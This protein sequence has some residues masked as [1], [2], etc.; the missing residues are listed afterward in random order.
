M[1]GKAL[2]KI[3][4]GQC[5]DLANVYWA[6]LFG[7]GLK[8]AG[9][10][11]IPNVNNF[12][13]EAHVYNN[14]QSF[15][16]KPGDVVVFPRTF[17]GGYGHVAIV[18]S[19]TLNVITVIEQNWNGGGLSKTEVATRRT[20]GYEFPM[21]FIRPFY[22]KTN[23]AKSTQSATVT[24]K[25]A[26]PKKRKMKTL[27]Y[28]RDEVKGYRLPNRGY[29]P[30]FIVL[31]NDAG[32]VNATA[33]NY[34]NG[35]VNAPESRLEAGIAHS[36]ISGNTVWQA[37]PES[38]IGWHTANAIGNKNG[39]GIEIC[40]SIGA[41]DKVFLANEQS[42][43]QESAR[44]LKKWG[45]PANR[46]T[47]R[48]HVEFSSTSCPHRSAKL[49]TGYDPVTQGLLPKAK[50]VQLK[51]YF[52][53]Q[54]RSYM[55]GKVPVA[56]VKKSTSSA[57]NTKSTVAGA[58]KKNNYGTYYMKEK[59]RFVNGN[60]PILA[61]TQG[62]FRSCP[63]AYNFQPGGYCDYDEVM[64]QDGHVWIGYTWKSKR[65]YLPIRTWNG[66]APPHHGVGTLWG[67]IK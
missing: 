17:G 56:T 7:H 29:K 53:K 37:L 1:H 62:P 60:Q 51:D 22:K 49:H 33:E 66:V 23:V 4:Y 24:K 28:I 58:W 50:Q 59:A 3:Y 38:R 64:L 25:K 39:Y 13:N 10:A 9:A 36:Y 19:A 55:D 14:T 20:H 5:F 52:I 54:I 18:I 11:D 26:T 34:H 41:S 61:R 45:L 16:A 31:H 63:V 42:A 46:N 67:S 44:M 21:W 30:K 12:T 57:S 27:K 40:Q 15:L 43:F 2:N 32:S 65:Y 48:L 47:V 35:L 6:K 8:G